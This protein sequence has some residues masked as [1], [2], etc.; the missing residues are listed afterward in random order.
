MFDAAWLRITKAKHRLDQ[1]PHG[2]SRARPIG[3]LRDD[4]RTGNAIVSSPRLALEGVGI[5]TGDENLRPHG[6]PYLS[7]RNN[8]RPPLERSSPAVN[9]PSAS[10][11]AARNRVVARARYS[12]LLSVPS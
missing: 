11:S 6:L 2:L 3:Q 12:V 4:S 7:N 8:A 5:N 9:V 1:G 10:A